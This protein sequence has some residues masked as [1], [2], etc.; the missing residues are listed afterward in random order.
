MINITMIDVK[1][2]INH[3]P[4]SHLLKRF[5]CDVVMKLLVLNH[6][7]YEAAGTM[8]FIYE[9]LETEVIMSKSAQSY[10]YPINQ[11]IYGRVQPER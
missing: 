8:T 7:V 2:D 3:S 10:I 6:A 5:D 1:F 11:H 4:L 9:R